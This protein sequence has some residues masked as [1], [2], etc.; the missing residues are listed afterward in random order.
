MKKIVCLL[1]ILCQTLFPAFPSTVLAAGPTL[2]STGTE[3]LNLSQKF[4]ATVLKGVKLDPLNPLQLEFLV[5]PG[6][7]SLTQEELRDESAKLLRYFLA[8]LT[9]PESDLWVNLSPYEQNRIIPEAFSQTEMGRDMLAQDHVLKQLAASLTNPETELGKKY[10]ARV[11]RLASGDIHSTQEDHDP[12]NVQTTISNLLA[13]VWIVP[14]KALVYENL[15]SGTAF[16]LE[17]KLQVML[18]EDYAALQK[19]LDSNGSMVEKNNVQPPTSNVPSSASQILREIILPELSK[20][21]NE[22]K[23]FSQLR[24]IYHSYILANW[25]K[26]K[27]KNS[28]LNQVYSDQNKVAGVDFVD[29]EEKQKIYTRYVQ[30]FK[31]GAY[32]LIREEVDP[33]TEEII[34]RK[35]FSGGIHWEAETLQT[36]ERLPINASSAVFDSL[37]R[38]KTSLTTALQRRNQLSEEFQAIQDT[39]VIPASPAPQSNIIRFPNNVEPLRSGALASYRRLFEENY[40]PKINKKTRAQFRYP[41]KAPDPIKITFNEQSR[42]IIDGQPMRGLEVNYLLFGH[43]KRSIG[44]LRIHHD[45]NETIMVSGLFSRDYLDP[46]KEVLIIMNFINFDYNLE[47]TLEGFENFKT[48]LL[49]EL[50]EGVYE[51]WKK[52]DFGRSEY[53]Q[54]LKDLYGEARYNKVL[55]NVSATKT[56]NEALNEELGGND[57]KNVDLALKILARAAVG[58]NRGN[59]KKALEIKSPLFQ[60]IIQELER[61]PQLLTPSQERPANPSM[62]RLILNGFKDIARIAKDNG[63]SQMKI[64]V[65]IPDGFGNLLLYQ[66]I[67]GLDIESTL[68]AHPNPEVYKWWGTLN[69][70]LIIAHRTKV[71][72][73]LKV[74]WKI[75]KANDFK[76]DLATF[77]ID[78]NQIDFTR[79][80]STSSQNPKTA[81]SETSSAPQITSQPVLE[82]E[83]AAS[84]AASTPVGGI[85]FN[86]DNLL[87]ITQTEGGEFE[88]D[89]NPFMMPGMQDIAGFSGTVLEINPV[90]NLELFLGTPA[91]AVIR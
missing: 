68:K 16:I 41:E 65:A 11:D 62:T 5:E 72:D 1:L 12:R 51:S 85:D 6:S 84:Q 24:Q 42:E 77:T 80:Q 15:K 70:A 39:P 87:L 27:V 88:F 45:D 18:E 53:A 10:W 89:A 75:V 48:A 36:T 34:P 30:A 79:D 73:M 20:E 25:Y 63:Y 4:D 13:K 71:W 19:T 8:A 14:Q 91:S 35:Y 82:P 54:M 33:V 9:V 28:I 47:E 86:P 61:A 29:P 64:Q 52:I 46:S 17:S 60:F 50:E 78:L 55:A 38:V 56:F 43:P 69:R 22:N 40:L 49:A 23:N 59:L 57:Y 81:P 26:Q 83:I 3:N 44:R 21:I 2:P 74:I 32:N 58:V 67:L 31:S 76:H 90:E 7:R 66:K 37:R